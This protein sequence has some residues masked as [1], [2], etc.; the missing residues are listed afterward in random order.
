MPNPADELHD[1]LEELVLWD[2]PPRWRQARRRVPA[3]RGGVP[4]ADVMLLEAASRAICADGRFQSPNSSN[5]QLCS[6]RCRPTLPVT[7]ATTTA[8]ADKSNP[9]RGWFAIVAG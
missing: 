5:G 3:R 2:R 7:A 9:T 4:A 6:Q 1:Q 8:A